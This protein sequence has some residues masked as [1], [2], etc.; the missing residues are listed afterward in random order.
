MSDDDTERGHEQGW[1]DAEAFIA[2]HPHGM[3]WAALPDAHDEP[4]DDY[5]R[6]YLDGWVERMREQGWPTSRS[7]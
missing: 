2:R 5:E 1:D 7:E 3:P 4:S 6:G